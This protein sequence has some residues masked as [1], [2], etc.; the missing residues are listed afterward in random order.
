[1]SLLLI[2]R[3]PKLTAGAETAASSSAWLRVD[4]GESQI[5]TEGHEQA[6]VSRAKP[7]GLCEGCMMRSLA[8]VSYCTQAWHSE[9]MLATTSRLLE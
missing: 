1:M 7:A 4:D 5:L 6:L 2:G 9:P 3:T 8:G